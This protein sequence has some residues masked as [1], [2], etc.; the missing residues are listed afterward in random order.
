MK[1]EL[2]AKKIIIVVALLLIAIIS[3]TVLAGPFS[4]PANHSSSVSYLDEKKE[5]VMKLVG[6]TTAVSVALAMVPGDS[7]TPAAGTLSDMNKYLIIILAVIVFEKYLLTLSGLAVFKILVPLA[8]LL[9]AIYVILHRER[10]KRFASKL[11]VLALVIFLVVPVSVRVSALI[12]RTYEDSVDA[13]ISSA[14]EFTA[15]MEGEGG[16]ENGEAQGEA[17]E[18]S[19]GSNAQGSGSGAASQEKED[20]AEE[21]P[22]GLGDILAALGENVRDVFD[23]AAG[24]VENAVES[25][26]GAA[27]LAMEKVERA[28][29]NFVESI[30][31]MLITACVI[32][33]AVLVFLW[34][35][36]KNLFNAAAPLTAAD[37]AGFEKR[38]KEWAGKDGAAPHGKKDA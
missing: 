21:K 17:G 38:L 24:T 32:P 27:S 22:S 14:D 30:S 23:K 33:V 2:N 11:L 1:P 13:A 6:G 5:T 7:T 34:I 28:I 18:S 29:G 37:L 12:D 9:Y 8:C 15:E 10:F 35:V 31:V 4:D 3:F 25:I 26:P 36:I 19:A 16:A 20:D